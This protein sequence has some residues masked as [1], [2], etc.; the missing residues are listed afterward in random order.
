MDVLVTV[1]HVDGRRVWG[2]LISKDATLYKQGVLLG[3]FPQRARSGGASWD[4]RCVIVRRLPSMHVCSLR[5]PCMYVC[6]SN[7]GCSM[8]V[9][10]HAQ[11]PLD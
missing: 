7:G 2:K 8:A 6:I 3:V 1:F 5:V 11:L 10:G 4:R 9:Y